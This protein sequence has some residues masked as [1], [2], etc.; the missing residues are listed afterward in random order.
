MR[1]VVLIVDD[2]PDL[3]QVMEE[4][5]TM[6]LPDHSVRTPS[7]GHGATEVL[8]ELV[9][10]GQPLA[11]VIADQLLGD[12]DGLQV[13]EEAEPTGARLILVTGRATPSIES[14]AAKLGATVLWKPFRLQALVSLLRTP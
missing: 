5:I 6:A 9:S 1:P 14:A 10:R 12:R 2:V 7:S 8:Q 13:L 11:L 3:L 4:A